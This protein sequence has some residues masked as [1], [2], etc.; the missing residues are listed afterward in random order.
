MAGNKHRP[1]LDTARAAELQRGLAGRIRRGD[2]PGPIRL[3]AGVDVSMAGERGRAAVVV[4]D[5]RTLEPIETGIAEGRVTVPYIP[6]FLAFREMPLIRR[7]FRKITSVPDLV[8]ADGMGLLHPRRFGLACHLGLELGLPAMGCG[9]SPFIGSFDEPPARRGS[10]SP[11]MYE[12]ERL[13][14]AL[15]TRHGVKVVFIST[16]HRISL[17]RAIR[18]ALRTSTEARLPQPIRLAHGASRGTG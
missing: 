14:A 7:A 13:G 5:A 1:A 9:K 17:R 18:W 2:R 4:M 16:G 12:G 6:G 15:R 10:W 11:V 3:I 8:M